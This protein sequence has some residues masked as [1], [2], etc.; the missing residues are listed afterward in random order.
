MTQQVQTLFADDI[1]GSAAEGTIC[2]GLDGTQHEIDL[3]AEHAQQ[4]AGRPGIPS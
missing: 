2:P 4:A 3:N 1:D